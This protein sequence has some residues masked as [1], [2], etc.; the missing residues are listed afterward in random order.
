MCGS[1]RRSLGPDKNNDGGRELMNTPLI[2]KIA[3]VGGGNMASALIQGALEAG[4]APDKIAVLEI[5]PEARNKLCAMGVMVSD[6]PQA[7]LRS[8]DTVVLAVK[9]QQMK[10]VCKDIQREVQQARIISIAAGVSVKDLSSWLL[11]HRRILRAMPNT[12]AL[13][14]RGVTGVYA[15]IEVDA[16][17]RAVADMILG[18]V[19]R[20]LWFSDEA[21][22]DAV[23]ALSGSGPAY[24]FHFLEGL[25]AAGT[26]MGLDSDT[27]KILALE[28]LA[29]ALTLAS[30]SS[31]T[32][33][34]LR[35]RV[36]SRGGTTEAALTYLLE[37][38]WV[39][40]LVAAIEAARE[41]SVLLSQQ[42]TSD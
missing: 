9:P 26:A 21:D 29:G 18:A 31:E 7:V 41:R 10:S 12:P 19:G 32:P 39:P 27:T 28:T 37:K 20:V 34:E 33:L 6:E 30:T 1:D 38:D 17:D 36:S 8:A 15:G 14:R 3:F 23:T 42:W 35:Q 13:V 4:T 22:L 2:Q 40:H 5:S 16:S 11:D 25:Y 24:V